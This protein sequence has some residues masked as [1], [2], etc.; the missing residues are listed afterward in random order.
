MVDL[1][2]KIQKLLKLDLVKIFSFTALSTFVKMLAGL[3]S[4]KVVAVMIGPS[5]IALLGQLNNFATIIM[6]LASGGINNGV[7]KYVSEYKSSDSEI[8]NLLSTGFKIT[9][10]CSSIIGLLLII[11]NELLSHKVLLI[12]AYGY[13]FIIFGIVL[14]FYALNSFIVSILN[15]FK[16][17]KLFVY[18]NIIGS[19]LGLIFTVSLVYFGGLKGAL[20][21]AISFQSVM[22]V[23]TVYMIRKLYWLKKSF[24]LEKFDTVWFRRY[25]GFTLMAFVTAATSPI[26]QLILRG[27]I[28]N[29]ISQIE[30][31][32]WEAMNRISNMY[33][34]V[35]TTSLSVYYLPRLSEISDNHLLRIE[36]FKAYKLIVPA[37]L[38]SFAAIFFL[39][40][41]VIQILFTAEFSGMERLFFWQL[42]GDFFKICSWLLAFLMVAKAMTKAYVITEVV[43]SF[44]FVF[45]SFYLMQFNG[46]VGITQAVFITYICYFICMIFMFRKILFIKHDHSI[47]QD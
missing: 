2:T 3:V 39:R 16:E 31:G 24:F 42:L 12:P 5:G 8:K 34:L 6:T 47:E 27:H 21:S 44:G 30:A 40:F 46:I 43:F 15:G 38:L 29:E 1:K 14:I 33:L 32:W 22:F 36:L 25:L 35:I 26:S 41:F 17:F 37:L 19:I 28:I 4:V 10:F 23:V 9:A 13:V 7:T 45:L 11:F 18:V 20:I